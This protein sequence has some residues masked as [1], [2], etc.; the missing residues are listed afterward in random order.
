MRDETVMW[1][2]AWAILLYSPTPQTFMESPASLT[3]P[4]YPLNN[5]ATLDI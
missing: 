5:C 4:Q 3:V 1:K 2:S